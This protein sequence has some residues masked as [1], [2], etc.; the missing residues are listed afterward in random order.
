MTVSQASKMMSLSERTTWSKRAVLLFAVM[1]TVLLQ[2]CASF[3]PV[4]ASKPLSVQVNAG[5][6]VQITTKNGDKASFV[7]SKADKDGIF[8]GENYY[9]YL[10]IA[11][12]NIEKSDST[13]NGLVLA[14]LAGVAVVVLLVT[15]VNSVEDVVETTLD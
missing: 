2:G 1:C 10:D 3:A 7:I 4:D 13:R 6:K 11:Q 15:V 9:P 8:D 14:A 5:D 12:M